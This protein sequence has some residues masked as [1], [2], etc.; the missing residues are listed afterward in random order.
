[1]ALCNGCSRLGGFLAPFATVALVASGRTRAAVTLLGS[2]CGAAALCAFLLPFETRGRDLQ[3]SELQLDG[4]RDLGA[5]RQ[6]QPAGGSSDGGGDGSSTGSLRHMRVQ[7][8]QRP[9]GHTEEELE[10]EPPHEHE[11]GGERA[12]L[13]PLPSGLAR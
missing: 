5:A 8:E 7:Q 4:S 10:L 6:Q 12:L 2:L 3:A 1:M 11:Q 9:R 13:L